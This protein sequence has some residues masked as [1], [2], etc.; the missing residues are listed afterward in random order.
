MPYCPYTNSDLPDDSCTSEH[1][2]PLALGGVN[3]F[4]LPVCKTSNK[5]LGSEIDGAIAN[6]FLILTRRN[7]FD[8]KG[9]SRKSPVFVAKRSRDADTGAPLQVH[10]DQRDGLK[11]WDPVRRADVSYQM[12]AR[13]EINLELKMDI[14]L[15]F[16]A[17]VALAAGYFAYG[18]YFREHVRHDELRTIMNNTPMELGEDICNLQTLADDRFSST[19][20]LRI[21]DFQ[22]I[23]KRLSPHSVVGIVPS[24]GRVAT[25]VGILGEYI[26][27]LNA[28]A[29]T[30][31]CPNCDDYRWGHIM[32]LGPN[33]QL[34]RSSFH[35]FY[36]NFKQLS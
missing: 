19:T 11:I 26:G 12:P 35:T 25:F 15:R 6:D 33:S 22:D 24:N 30:A 13:L 36:K 14:E 3:R 31:T 28:P 1:I 17:K 18:K 29:D 32:L 8:V 2:I 5:T 7:K 16:V 34:I 23:C 4:Q 10:L 9:H 21:K 27:M 20:S